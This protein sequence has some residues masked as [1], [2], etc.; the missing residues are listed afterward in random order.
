L[1]SVV[2]PLAE[3]IE[4]LQQ[5]DGAGEALKSLVDRYVPPRTE[6]KDLLSGT[7]LGHPLHPVLTDVVLGAWTS[8]FLLDLL[9][10]RRTRKAS[11]LLVDIGILAAAPTALAGLSDWADVWG[12][13]RRV[14]LVHASA[15][16]VALSL[17]V[18]SSLARKRGRRLR[19]W[20]LSVAGFGVITTSAYLGG[21][22]SLGKGIGVDQTAFDAGPTDWQPVI[23]DADLAEGSPTPVTVGAVPLLLVRRGATIHAISNRCNHRGCWLH[24]GDFSGETSVVCPCHGSTFSLEDGALL[25]GPAT[26]PQPAYLTRVR[27][28]QVEVRLAHT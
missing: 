20:W 5:L 15:N 16:A 17:Y 18:R 2:R 25:H 24:E 12:R 4:E 1:R 22:L 11:D 9:P 3:R 27:D 21:H 14:G 13:P 26:A 23:T 10:G 19:G 7:W 8:S 6:L 28:G